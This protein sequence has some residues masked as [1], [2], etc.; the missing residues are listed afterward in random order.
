MSPPRNKTAELRAALAKNPDPDKTA[1]EAL[2]DLLDVD[3]FRLS[4]MISRVRRNPWAG[5]GPAR[6]SRPRAA[7]PILDVGSTMGVGAG[8]R[9]ET[10]RHYNSCLGDLAKR[11]NGEGHCPLRCTRFVEV[12]RGAELQARARSGRAAA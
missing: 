3:S 11:T 1:R 5:T 7:L 2:C 6:A 12:D 4:I 9:R 8:E 10:C